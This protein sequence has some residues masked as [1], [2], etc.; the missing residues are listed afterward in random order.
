MAQL[1]NG[2]RFRFP[3]QLAIHSFVRP[4]AGAAGFL[5]GGPPV[6]TNDTPS[7]DFEWQSVVKIKMT[8]ATLGSLKGSLL[9]R[10]ICAPVLVERIQRRSCE[11]RSGLQFEWK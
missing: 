10:R 4:I 5:T 1:K 3:C 8:R 7:C 6:E 11:A 2:L 9:A